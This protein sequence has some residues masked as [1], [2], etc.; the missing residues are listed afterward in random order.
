[1]I[2]SQP[3]PSGRGLHPSLTATTPLSCVPSARWEFSTTLTSATTISLS[4]LI[5]LSRAKDCILATPVESM[6]VY[7]ASI[8]SQFKISLISTLSCSYSRSHNTDSLVNL[9]SNSTSHSSKWMALY[10]STAP[11]AEKSWFVTQTLLARTTSS[12]ATIA[13]LILLMCGRVSRAIMMSAL[14]V[15]TL[16]HSKDRVL[17][18]TSPSS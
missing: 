1:V 8:N 17:L 7:I 9:F 18:N 13:T 15:A 3:N 5:A 2:I 10:D 11:S 12:S 6:R 16:C 14:R 4:V